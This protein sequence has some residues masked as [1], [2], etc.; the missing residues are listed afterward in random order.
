MPSHS[1]PRV[2]TTTLIPDASLRGQTERE[3]QYLQEYARRARALLESFVWCTGIRQLLYGV[4]AGGVIAVFFADV[5]IKGKTR[6]WLWVVTGD[7]P[8]A[9]LPESAGPTPCAALSAYCEGAAAW[10]AAVLAGALGP[11]H[12]AL[13]AEASPEVAREVAAKV[14]TVQRLVLPV[15]CAASEPASPG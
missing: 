5:L 8:A 1:S 2:D 4:G 13:S 15:L 10:A 12:L 14:A 6:E 3:T 7:L 11:Q 9:Y